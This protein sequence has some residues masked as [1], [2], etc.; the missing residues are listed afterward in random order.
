MIVTAAIQHEEADENQTRRYIKQALLHEA[1]Q[2]LES[3]RKS[4][5]ATNRIK[6]IHAT[7]REMKKK[8]SC[9]GRWEVEK[10]AVFSSEQENTTLISEIRGPQTLALPSVTTFGSQENRTP[11]LTWFV[12]YWECTKYTI[13]TFWKRSLK[14]FISPG[15]R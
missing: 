12:S 15:M 2:F 14:K 9:Y 10:Q 8:R 6:S 3:C 5:T 4:N 13:P 11:V 1:R 7:G